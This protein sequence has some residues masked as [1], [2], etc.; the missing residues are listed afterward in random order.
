MT[1]ECILAMQSIDQLTTCYLVLKFSC[2]IDIGSFV[3]DYST[4]KTEINFKVFYL[5]P[6]SAGCIINT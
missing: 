5:P 4:L 6:Y 3:N 1:L 2:F